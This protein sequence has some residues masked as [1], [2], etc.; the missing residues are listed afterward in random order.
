MYKIR[1]GMA[2]KGE[3]KGR[4]KVERGGSRRR[5]RQRQKPNKQPTTRQPQQLLRRNPLG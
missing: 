4:G 5:R 2:G 1:V 3:N